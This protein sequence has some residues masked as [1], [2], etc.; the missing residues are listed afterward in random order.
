V[1]KTQLRKKEVAD[2]DEAQ[3]SVKGKAM[4]RN[5]GKEGQLTRGGEKGIAVLAGRK[6]KK[7]R[8]YGKK[9]TLG[10]LAI[11]TALSE[12][13]EMDPRRCESH[14]GHCRGRTSG[15]SSYRSKRGT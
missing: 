14:R 5:L 2:A 9:A 13:R 8:M 12:E 3:M 4:F 10:G 6:I 7:A 11:K 15:R 1:A